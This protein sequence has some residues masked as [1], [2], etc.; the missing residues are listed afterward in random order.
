MFWEDCVI[1]S[2][3]ILNETQREVKPDMK[4]HSPQQTSYYIN[5]AVTR[6]YF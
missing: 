2:F 4:T 5:G 3:D 1:F 6:M